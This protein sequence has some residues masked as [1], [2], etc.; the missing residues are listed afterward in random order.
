MR[1]MMSQA[2][3]IVVITF[4]LA[5]DASAQTG[6]E[7]TRIQ[8]PTQEGSA[9]LGKKEQL[10]NL[11]ENVF[12]RVKM[13][14]VQKTKVTKIFDDFFS[15]VEAQKKSGTPITK[16]LMDKTI[17]AK[18]AQLKAI[19]NA[20]QIKD[21]V[22]AERSIVMESPHGK[23]QEHLRKQGPPKEMPARKSGNR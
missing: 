19:L 7:K 15:K 18:D 13:S 4:I 17:A 22:R 2:I 20:E 16:E 9:T 12:P 8:L 23:M 5:A 6:R 10:K 3:L 11:N 14:Q 1:K 21:L